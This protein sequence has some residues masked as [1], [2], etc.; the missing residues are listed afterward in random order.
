MRIVVVGGTGLVGRRVVELLT[1]GGHEVVVA[2]RSTGVDVITTEGLASAVNGADVVIDA[3]NSPSFEAEIALPF[4]E[5]STRNILSAAAEA[6]VQQHVALSIVGAERLS[7]NGYFR[8]KLAQERLV[9][10]GGVPFTI[11][12]STQ[13][14]EFLDRI[15]SAS[16]AGDAV[17]VAPARVHPIAAGDTAAALAEIAMIRPS[18]GTIEIAGPDSFKL[19]QLVRIYM[20]ATND[21]RRVISDPE[22][23]YFGTKLNDET[24]MAGGNPRFGHTDF[25]SWFRRLKIAPPV[26]AMR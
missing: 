9:E 2:A 11:L 12:R 21:R 13:F 16:V 26:G 5:T 23:L 14:F 15:I 4:F 6:S 24:L 18:N 3:V 20:S 25:D 17:R 8:A 7:A 19:D 1:R 22:A 10:A